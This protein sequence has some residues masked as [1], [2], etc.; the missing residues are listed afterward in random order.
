MKHR[1]FFDYFKKYD[2]DFGY[3]ETWNREINSWLSLLYE[4]D[5]AFYQTAKTRVNTAKQRDEFLGEAKAIYYFHNFLGINKFEFEPPGKNQKKLDFSYEQD[6]GQRQ[7]KQRQT[8]TALQI[9]RQY[10]LWHYAKHNNIHTAAI[11][12]L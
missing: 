12:W 10:D 3:S 4:L 7:V 1:H 2:D 9:L 11:S 6:N 5:R 8:H